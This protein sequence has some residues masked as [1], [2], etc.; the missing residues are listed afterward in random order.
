LAVVSARRMLKD[1]VYLYTFTWRVS[2]CVFVLCVCAREDV[3]S[4]ETSVHRTVVWDEL[5]LE[6]K[7]ESSR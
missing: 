5:S 1:L 7:S 6:S 4:D 2:E 3:G